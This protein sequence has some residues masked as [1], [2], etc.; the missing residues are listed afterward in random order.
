MALYQKLSYYFYFY[1]FSFFFNSI[2]KL[3]LFWFFLYFFL[4]I[5]ISW[6]QI[7]L[8]LL[9]LTIV[10]FRHLIFFSLILHMRAIDP[11][12]YVCWIFHFILTLF[13]KAFDNFCLLSYFLVIFIFLR[14]SIFWKL[15][16]VIVLKQ[17]WTVTFFHHWLFLNNISKFLTLVLDMLN[18]NIR[19]SWI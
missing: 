4:F 2:I 17:R 5:R 3:W 1:S 11:H 14:Y 16:N 13:V 7:F 9:W 6:L 8:I 10:W 18:F 15:W 12:F 19:E